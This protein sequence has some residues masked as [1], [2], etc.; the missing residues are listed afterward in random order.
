M[1]SKE[2]YW[3]CFM[4]VRKVGKSRRGRKEGGR[5]GKGGDRKGKEVK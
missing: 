4:Y 2:K 3:K 1:F 5:E